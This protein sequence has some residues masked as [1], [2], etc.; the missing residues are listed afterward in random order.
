MAGIKESKK[1][2]MDGK[3]IDWKDANIHVLSHVIH[4]GTNA[5]EGIRA[6][7]RKDG[8]AIFRLTDHFSRLY[9]TAKIYH[10]VPEYTKEELI[11]AVKEL[12]RVNKLH[13][14][15]IRPFIFRGYNTLGIYPLN[16]PLQ[17]VLAAWEWGKYLGEEACEKGIRC[18]ISSW[19]RPAPKTFPTM[20]KI[21]G[22]YVNSQLMKIE[23]IQD[24]FD[25]AIAL[26]SYGFVSEGSGEN[27]FTVK[28][29]VIF[30]PP[31]SSAILAGITRHSI[32]KLARELKMDI[33]Q[34]VLPRESL[35]IADEVFLTGTA[36][37]ITP[38]T[39]ID[40]IKIK[41]GLKGPITARLQEKFFGI[42]H[43][44]HEDL[45]NWMTEV[46]F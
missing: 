5:F 22:N 46:K 33:K 3:F 9:D 30:T 25:E 41:D 15:Y 13:Q 42:T 38:V 43:G 6:Y 20:A 29:G 21:A 8:T 12:M 40:N 18:R 1:I 24:E 37:E 31:T 26:D 35:Y 23:A 11:E 4:Y 17:V 39:E 28:N 36:A 16:C 19:H 10:L 14:A 27:I 7:P 32:F 34:H 2:W 45:F 44:D